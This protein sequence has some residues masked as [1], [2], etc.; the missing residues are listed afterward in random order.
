MVSQQ[1][2]T[3]INKN[4]KLNKS[5]GQLN[6]KI[7]SCLI[8]FSFLIGIQESNAQILIGPNVGL[9]WGIFSFG[10]TQALTLNKALLGPSLGAIVE[11][12]IYGIL[13]VRAEPSYIQKGSD[14]TVD[15]SLPLETKVYPQYLQIPVELQANLPMTIFTPHVFLGPNVGFLLSGKGQWISAFDPEPEFDVKNIIKNID[16]GMDFGAGLDFSITPLIKANIDFKYSLGLP[17]ILKPGAG[18]TLLTAY[19]HGY[20]VLVG[21]LF[22]I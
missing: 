6:W 8:V 18:T 15:N 22:T 7:K 13:S 1:T 16:F 14:F 19:T 3:A 11:I 5:M 9:N 17:N 2:V 21:V 4:K 12:P 20:Q 10:N